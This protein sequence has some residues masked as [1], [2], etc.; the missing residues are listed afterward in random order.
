MYKKAGQKRHFQNGKVSEKLKNFL[1]N[2]A[3]LMC[4]ECVSHTDGFQVN[5]SR[6]T[7]RSC[8]DLA[9]LKGLKHKLSAMSPNKVI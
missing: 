5:H 9:F 2:T 1:L 8:L 6:K 3:L 7:I 4:S